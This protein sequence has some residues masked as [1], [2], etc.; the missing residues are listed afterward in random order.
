MNKYLNTFNDIL[1]ELHTKAKESNGE[2]GNSGYEYLTRILI[3]DELDNYYG[4]GGSWTL[5]DKEQE[6][7]IAIIHEFYLKTDGDISL[8]QSTKAVCD[9]MES[10]DTFENFREMYK[11][12]YNEVYDNFVWC[13]GSLN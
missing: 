3:A 12:E 1:A 7:L 8:Y 10:Y 6:E 13:L 4:Q 5:T 2:L 9:A 11:Q